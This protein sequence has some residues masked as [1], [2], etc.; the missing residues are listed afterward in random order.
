MEAF[1]FILDYFYV[2]CGLCGDVGIF[3]DSEEEAKIAWNE[4]KRLERRM[5][6]FL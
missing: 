5:S 6:I 4:G 1:V 3:E 2:V